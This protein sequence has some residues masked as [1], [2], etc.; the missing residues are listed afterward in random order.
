MDLPGTTSGSCRPGQ[1]AARW[2]STRAPRR[3]SPSSP[4]CP[5]EIRAPAGRAPTAPGPRSG[6]AAARAFRRP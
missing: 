4:S 5:R 3:A 2:R 6:L 1:P